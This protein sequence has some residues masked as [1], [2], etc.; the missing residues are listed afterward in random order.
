MLEGKSKKD[1]PGHQHPGLK[2]LGRN[3]AGREELSPQTSDPQGQGEQSGPAQ[4]PQPRPTPQPRNSSPRLGVG[5][6][7]SQK[8]SDSSL[9]FGNQRIPGAAPWF[10]EHLT[11]C[12][13]PGCS[14]GSKTT[15]QGHVGCRHGASPAWC[16]STAR[17]RAQSCHPTPD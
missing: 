12:R 7:I 5:T 15:M 3:R 2:R 14:A 1:R 10:Y 13:Q 17:P 16:G 9:Y 6:S 8:S 11:K 4:H